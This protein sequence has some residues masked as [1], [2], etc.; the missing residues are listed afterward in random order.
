MTRNEHSLSKGY[1]ENNMKLYNLS[2]N[3]QLQEQLFLIFSQMELFNL[4]GGGS[5][6]KDFSKG[7]QH[8]QKALARRKT[9]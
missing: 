2:Y 3:P 8:K 6:T 1:L 4:R 9:K 7:L 5:Q